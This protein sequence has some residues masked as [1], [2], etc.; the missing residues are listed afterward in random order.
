VRCRGT[1]GHVAGHDLDRADRRHAVR[2]AMTP[3]GYAVVPSGGSYQNEHEQ[4][5]DNKPKTEYDSPTHAHA[6][7]TGLVPHELRGM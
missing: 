1:A 2:A 6:R 3:S 5:A 7:K 4:Q